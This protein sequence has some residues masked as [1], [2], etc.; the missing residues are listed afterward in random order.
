LGAF[1]VA[2]RILA[3]IEPDEAQR[4]VIRFAA[5]LHDIGH[6]PFSHVSEFALSQ[7]LDRSRFG[8]ADDEEIHERLTWRILRRDG[9]IRSIL[10]DVQLDKVV[11]LL[12]HQQGYSYQKGILSGPLDAD[13][14][15]YL[16]RDT[17][18][19]G[20]KYGIFDLPRLIQTLEVW[21][22]GD[23]QYLIVSEDGLHSVEQ[24]VLAKYY[25]TTQVYCHRLRLITDSMLERAVLLGVERDGLDFLQ[26]IYTYDESDEYVDGYLGW[27]DER[28]TAELLR[29]RYAET[30]AG[31]IFQALADRRLWKLVFDREVSDFADSSVKNALIGGIPQETART[32]EQQAAHALSMD[33]SLV[34][35]S[36]SSI[37]SVREQGRSNEASLLV[38]TRRGIESFDEAS[39][40]FRSIDERLKEQRVQVYGPFQFSDDPVAKSRQRKELDEKIAG[41]LEAVLTDRKEG[42]GCAAE[43]T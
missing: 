8:I 17:Y 37:K 38:K 30:Q 4:E 41:I 11:G 25:L 16:L 21:E 42:S 10:G 35:L 20:V 36:V 27:T 26:E 1:H 2:S 5:L 9:D 22:D 40:L 24:F 43:T 39:T 29:E 18:F 23:D 33:P 3:K 13:K 19:C 12:R 15:D 6:G 7:F 31:R 32:V 28:L 14:L 34:V